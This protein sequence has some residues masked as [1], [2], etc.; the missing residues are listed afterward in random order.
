MRVDR[1]TTV[2]FWAVAKVAGANPQFAI[3][4]NDLP[5][6]LMSAEGAR[7]FAAAVNAEL[8][9]VDCAPARTAAA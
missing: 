1:P 7:E 3:K 8:E 5:P 6:V 2:E 4:F 9:G